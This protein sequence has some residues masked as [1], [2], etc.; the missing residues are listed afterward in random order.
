M[1]DHAGTLRCEQLARRSRL[2]RPRVGIAAGAVEAGL[3]ERTVV[4]SA[5]VMRQKRIIASG[6]LAG[7]R[8]GG[9]GRQPSQS[10]QTLQESPARR[11]FGRHSK[12]LLGNRL[13]VD[14]TVAQAF[15]QAGQ[16][17]A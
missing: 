6:A 12:G 14:Y 8:A 10:P 7:L 17:S 16:A 5:G 3:F 13:K 15:V 1:G 2:D 9:R 11:E 4:L